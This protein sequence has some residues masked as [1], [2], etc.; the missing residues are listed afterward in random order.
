MIGGGRRT[1]G[2]PGP[3][4]WDIEEESLGLDPHNPDTDGDG[5]KDGEDICPNLSKKTTP[6]DEDSELI[7][8]AFFALY[9]ISGSRQMLLVSPDSK[10]VHIWGYGGPIIYD[11]ATKPFQKQ[12]PEGPI[13]MH[14]KVKAKTTD[15]ATVQISDYEGPLAAWGCDVQLK[16]IQGLWVVVGT[17]GEWIS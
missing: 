13:T 8:E 4:S 12:H 17:S 2:P 1:T 6:V 15:S 3:H 11:S 14:W 10:P 9:G 5:I 7:Q 16:K